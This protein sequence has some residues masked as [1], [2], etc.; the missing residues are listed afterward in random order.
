MDSTKPSQRP[1]ASVKERT[2]LANAAHELRTPLHSANGFLEMALEGMAGPL[3]ERQHEMLEYA[4]IAINQLGILIED[5]LFVARADT[6]E[7]VPH[8]AK[9][10]PATLVARALEAI[11]DT[12]REKNVTLTQTIG[13][14]PSSIRVDGERVREGLIGLLRSGLILTPPGGEL[15]IATQ[16]DDGQFRVIVSLAGVRL[17]A[18]DLRHLFDRFSQPRPLG[19]EKSAHL[20]L[21][22]VIAQITAA[23]HG[24]CAR[25]ETDPVG[26]LILSYTLPLNDS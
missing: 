16:A 6:G 1:N 13:E 20:G 19:A 21:G 23:W 3:G 26:S 2:F 18:T 11:R 22:L 10:T 25:A 12:A 14:A 15:A 24:G 5:V 4:H 8:P 7:L 17:D 9:A